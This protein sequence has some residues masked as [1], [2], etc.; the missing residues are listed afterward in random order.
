MSSD[1]TLNQRQKRAIGSLAVATPVFPA[2]IFLFQRG[3]ARIGLAAHQYILGTVAG[4]TSITTA[5]TSTAAAS[6]MFQQIL[7]PSTTIMTPNN[8]WQRSFLTFCGYALVG[9][10][11][12]RVLPSHSNHPGAFAYESIPAGVNYKTAKEA[13]IID[14]IGFKYGCHSCGTKREVTFI[15]DHQPPKSFQKPSMRFY[16]HCTACSNT[17]GGRISAGITNPAGFMVMH[18]WSSFLRARYWMPLL[19]AQPL[20][21]LVSVTE[22]DQLNLR[23][24]VP[25]KSDQEEWLFQEISNYTIFA[26]FSFLLILDGLIDDVIYDM[27]PNSVANQ[28]DDLS[29]L[30]LDDLTYLKDLPPQMIVDL[31][32][33]RVQQLKR[34]EKRLKKLQGE[35]ESHRKRLALVQGLLREAQSMLKD[36]KSRKD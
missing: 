24:Y 31:L 17:Q 28:V 21:M 11:P 22:L 10:S 13:R 35:D 4:M 32:Q 33:Q 29:D 14:R 9:P 5:S 8:L 7:D 34:Q 1:L 3:F 19:I 25:L 18:H 27:A 23:K 26:I 12:R 2:T 30:M 36:A 16:P 15:G 6:L 20:A